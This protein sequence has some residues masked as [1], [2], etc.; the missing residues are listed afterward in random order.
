MR[1]IFGAPEMPCREH[2]LLSCN[3]A[4]RSPVEE[5][6]MTDQH[7]SS[8]QTDKHGQPPD[9]DADETFKTFKDLVNMTPAQI[10]KWLQTDESRD[11]GQKSGGNESVGH[12]SGRHIIAIL[13]KKK[14][15]LSEAD[16][17]H[18]RKVIG[19][20]KR[21]LAQRPNDVEHSNWRYSLMNWGHDPV[22]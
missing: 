14:A 21:H 1:C 16:Y 3:G 13:G 6:S 20:I 15:D 2:C 19:Y 4:N 9:G 10:E 12:Q 8:T 11:V 22:K 18:M 5:D 7:R 17:A